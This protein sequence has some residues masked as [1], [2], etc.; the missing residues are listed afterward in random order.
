MRVAHSYRKFRTKIWHPSVN[1]IG[2]L[3]HWCCESCL[4]SVEHARAGHLVL[5]LRALPAHTGDSTESC[6]FNSVTSSYAL[7]P[8]RGHFA[9]TAFI[10]FHMEIVSCIHS[11]RSLVPHLEWINLW[12]L[13][14]SDDIPKHPVLHP[15]VSWGVI[16]HFLLLPE[17]HL[18][19]RNHWPACL[20]P[21]DTNAS[22]RV[23]LLLEP[24]IALMC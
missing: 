23:H 11:L 13:P 1:Y 7:P 8:R 21:K 14:K 6:H 17:K 20:F 12:F 15:L 5:L 4:V 24:V 9:Q 16:R 22:G 2:T 18:D 19:G 3:Y 10:M